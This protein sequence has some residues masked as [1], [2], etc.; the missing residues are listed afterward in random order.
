MSLA[1]ADDCV[2]YVNAAIYESYPESGQLMTNLVDG[3][4]SDM[5]FN[6][7]SNNLGG[8]Q[9]Y[10]PLTKSIELP[11]EGT[12]GNSFYDV[13]LVSTSTVVAQTMSVWFMRLNTNSDPQE[14]FID[15]RPT[16]GGYILK[17]AS[18][19][20]LI[21]SY[22]TDADIYIDGVLSTYTDFYNI[23]A[24]QW[25]NVV[26]V[27]TSTF[28][29]TQVCVFCNFGGNENTHVDFRA[30]AFFNRALT[31]SEIWDNY[32]AFLLNP[33][34]PLVLS[35][36][37][38]PRPTSINASW[39]VVSPS[40]I[41]YR[42]DIESSGVP[43]KSV[44]TS[45]NTK[46]IHGLDPETAYNV[47]LFY[48]ED[49]VTYSTS[50]LSEDT[51]TLENIGSNYAK[52]DYVDSEGVYDLTSDEIQTS[53]ILQTF[54]NGEQIKLNIQNMDTTVEFLGVGGSHTISDD[55]DDNAIL[56]PFEETNGYGQS[57]SFN[58]SG[59]GTSVLSFDNTTG[60][61]GVSGETYSPG[62]YFILDNKKVRIVDI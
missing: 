25:V 5:I 16:G 45:S 61:I 10:K 62:E 2:L 11:I 1:G 12:S 59:G 35:L 53:S 46:I 37:L 47:T 27:P 60:E 6:I 33:E 13:S 48:S 49:G 24:L 23:P 54:T 44:T 42:L 3:G 4:T 57:I 58:L 19:T 56:I 43:V 7:P 34:L 55:N 29:D 20:M 18:G 14:F 32:S 26:V 40:A 22:Y 17:Q 52:S 38:L 30:L 9:V 21:G 28:T 15:V 51:T 39:G 31:A 36:D 8:P 41:S 50:G